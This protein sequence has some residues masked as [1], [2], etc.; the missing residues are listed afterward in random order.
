[1]G[2]YTLRIYKLVVCFTYAVLW[3]YKIILVH[4]D[5]IFLDRQQNS[6]SSP[7]INILAAMNRT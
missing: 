7:L 2:F 6:V 4:H 3:N 1:M 5:I